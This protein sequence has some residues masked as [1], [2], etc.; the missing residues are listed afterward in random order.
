[1]ETKC[2][3]EVA[4]CRFSRVLLIL[5]FNCL[6]VSTVSDKFAFTGKFIIIRPYPPNLHSSACM[7]ISNFEEILNGVLVISEVFK[8]I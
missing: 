6:L 3:L 5:A 4:V 7:V 1:M 8:Q 2:T